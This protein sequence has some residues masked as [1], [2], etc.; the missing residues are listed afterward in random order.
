M[1]RFLE[2]NSQKNFAEKKI[3]NCINS[4][5]I[6]KIF[7]NNDNLTY[8]KLGVVVFACNSSYLAGGG[9]WR[10]GKSRSVWQRQQYPVSKTKYKI[11]GLRVWFRWQCPCL[12][13]SRSWVQT[14]ITQKNQLI[15]YAPQRKF[16]IQITSLISS[17]KKER[18]LIKFFSKQK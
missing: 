10:I 11:K 9:R 18:R 15:N 13:S 17:R 12:V 3:S 5:N 14:P 2:Q 16:Q 8:R 1:K 4:T 6:G 7:F